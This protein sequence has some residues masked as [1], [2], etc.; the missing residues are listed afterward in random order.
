MFPPRDFLVFS[1]MLSLV[2]EKTARTCIGRAYYAAHLSA[3]EKV[4]TRYPRLFPCPL[5]GRRNEH[6]IVRKTMRKDLHRPDIALNLLQ[7]SRKRVRA[8]Y[9]LRNYL[10]QTDFL[11]EAGRAITLC[12]T[13]LT[14]LQS[15]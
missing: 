10:S 15:V 9:D 1:K 5:R 14:N 3:R 11:I 4:R 6:K 8:D 13:I 7:L 12:E 2:D